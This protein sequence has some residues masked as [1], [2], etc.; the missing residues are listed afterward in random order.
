MTAVAQDHAN[1]H[2][3]HAAHGAHENHGIKRYVVI[4]L[5]LLVF[6]GLTYVT[7]KMDLGDFNIVLAMAIATTKASLVVMF[8]MHLWDEGNINRLVF[9]LSVFFAILLIVGVFG[10]LI[11]RLPVTLPPGMQHPTP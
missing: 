5:I 7:G 4:Y 3:E 9:V 8:F 11:F 2:S 1:I 10:D 6:T